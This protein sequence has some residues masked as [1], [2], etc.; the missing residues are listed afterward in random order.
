MSGEEILRVLVSWLGPSAV[1]TGIAYWLFQTFSSKWLDAKFAE[2]LEAYRH[3][4][5]KELERL[6]IEIDGS[7]DAV[8]RIQEREFTVVT[9][10]WALLQKAYGACFDAI[11]PFQS[12]PD[13][14]R[15]NEKERLDFYSRLELSA[16]SIVE[17]EEAKDRKTPFYKAYR[18]VQFS[19]AKTAIIEFQNYM[20]LNE[21]FLRSEVAN[22]LKAIGRRI[23]DCWD[24][25][26]FDFKHGPTGERNEKG[27][28]SLAGDVKQSIEALSIELRRLLRRE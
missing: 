22:E 28:P 27:Y 19:R 10:A 24:A 3:E 21:L 6:K 4:K 8:V 23:F 18:T 14:E 17:L 15:M 20:F 26:A 1:A 9:E 7:L 5:A 13:I 16:S 12:I 11:S 25:G 2:K